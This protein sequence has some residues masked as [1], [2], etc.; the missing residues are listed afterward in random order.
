MSLEANEILR[1]ACY[2]MDHAGNLLEDAHLLYRQRRWASSLML[3]VFTIEEM[4]KAELLLA[5]AI[6][7]AAN[8][9]MAVER[10]REGLGSHKAKLAAG[11]GPA[12]VS[13]PVPFFG[14]P[15]QLTPEEQAELERRLDDAQQSAL[16][17]APHASHNAR[18][19]ALYVDLGKNSWLRPADITDEEAYLQ[20]SAA[21]IEYDI[22]RRKFVDPA[23][24]Y[25]RETLGRMATLLPPLPPA[26][27]VE[28]PQDL[29]PVDH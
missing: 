16:R 12:S 2:A 27:V 26:P 13:A 1:G 17:N 15:E 4:G 7:A 23:E 3:A 24:A 6:E 21:A 11:R 9:P 28:W 25:V 5:R 8:G 19:R 14:D 20:L 29:P 22:R 10:V 18:M